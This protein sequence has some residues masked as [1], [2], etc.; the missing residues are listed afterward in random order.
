MKAAG[1]AEQLTLEAEVKPRPRRK[2]KSGAE[3]VL[4]VLD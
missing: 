3:K 2:A 1:L 4:Q